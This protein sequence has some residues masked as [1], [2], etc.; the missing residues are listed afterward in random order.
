[1][2]PLPI[3]VPMNGE[4]YLPSFAGLLPEMARWENQATR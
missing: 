1:M 2:S 4:Q 3:V